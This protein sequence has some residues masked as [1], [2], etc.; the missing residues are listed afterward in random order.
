MLRPLFLEWSREAPI[1]IDDLRLRNKDWVEMIPVPDTPDVDAI[2]SKFFVAK[3]KARNIQFSA[4]K[5]A[6]VYL[7]LGNEKY[8][9]IIT[10]LERLEVD[11]LGK[12]IFLFL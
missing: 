9:E 11:E 4:G 12:V 1:S 7:E 3:G 2:A 6:E 5:G 10:R 8:Q